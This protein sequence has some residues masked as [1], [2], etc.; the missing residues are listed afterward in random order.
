M[1]NYNHD[2]NEWEGITVEYLQSLEKAYPKV[3][4]I[5]EFHKMSVW[6]QANPKKGRKKL[7]S[8]FVA[9]WLSRKW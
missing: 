6:I 9:N 1:I 3:D 4:V 2:T 8:R 5:Q 7:W